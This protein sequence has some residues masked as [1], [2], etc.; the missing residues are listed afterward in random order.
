MNDYVILT[1]STSD[2]PDEIVKEFGIEVLPME[3]SIDGKSYVDGEMSADEF[4]EKIKNKLSAST[5]QINPGE[6][7]HPDKR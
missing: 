4:Y 1:D 5:S 7:R 6:Q 2:L 3:F